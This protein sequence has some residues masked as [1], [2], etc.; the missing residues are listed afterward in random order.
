MSTLTILN[1]YWEQRRKD[2]TVTL[3]FLALAN[4]FLLHLLNII[5]QCTFH[6]NSTVYDIPVHNVMMLIEVSH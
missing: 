1:V 5:E 2:C 6:P 3:V 4:F